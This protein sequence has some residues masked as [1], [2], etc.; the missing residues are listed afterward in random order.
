M[1]ATKR[2]STACHIIEQIRE[3]LWPDGDMDAVW[4]AETIERVAELVHPD[5]YELPETTEK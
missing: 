4:D 3:I 1:Q 5:Q 2:S